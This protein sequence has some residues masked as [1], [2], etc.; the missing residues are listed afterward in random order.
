MVLHPF[1]YGQPGTIRL[2]GCFQLESIADED[3]AIAGWN[4]D[5]RYGISAKAKCQQHEREHGTEGY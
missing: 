2:G 4:R 3:D 1:Q 5:V